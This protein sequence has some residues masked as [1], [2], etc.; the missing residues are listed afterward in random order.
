L[1]FI[2]IG[3][4]SKIVNDILL[5]KE[6]SWDDILSRSYN[7]RVSLTHYYKEINKDIIM[8][9]IEKRF[10]IFCQKIQ[11][12]KKKYYDIKQKEEEN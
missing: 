11:D 9:Y 4:E 10:D 12:I 6:G 8:N 1:N 7:L 5:E 3:E 2:E